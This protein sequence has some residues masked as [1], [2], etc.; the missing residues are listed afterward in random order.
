M[1]HVV[2]RMKARPDK[3]EQLAELAAYNSGCSRQEPGNLRFDVMRG[4]ENPLSFALYEV[5]VDEAAFKA[6]Q[7]TP[8]YA[9]WKAEIDGLLAEPRQSDR[10]VSVA[11]SPYV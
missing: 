1:Y 6:H 10:Y 4:T 8:H 5:Y 7:G 11:P 9:R 2:V 3:A